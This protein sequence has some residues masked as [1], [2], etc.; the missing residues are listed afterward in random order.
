VLLYLSS[1][2]LQA[3]GFQNSSSPLIPIFSNIFSSTVYPTV[4]DFSILHSGIYSL[5]VPVFLFFPFLQALRV[6]I[7]FSHP[8]CRHDPTSCYIYT[9]QKIGTFNIIKILGTRFLLRIILYFSKDIGFFKFY[10]IFSWYID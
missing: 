2:A 10:I 3:L 4:V 6:W 9:R 7:F 5:D 1:L 8:L